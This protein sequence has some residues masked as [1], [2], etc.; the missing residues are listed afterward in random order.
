MKLTVIIL[1][2]VITRVALAAEIQPTHCPLCLDSET[3]DIA[4]YAPVLGKPEEFFYDP[5]R[6]EITVVMREPII[7]NICNTTNLTDCS[8]TPGGIWKYTYGVKKNKLVLLRKVE[9]KIVPAKGESVEW[10]GE[11]TGGE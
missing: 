7:V 2:A 4:E 1:L 6:N 3:A 5:Q 10:P 11:E 8:S 9:G